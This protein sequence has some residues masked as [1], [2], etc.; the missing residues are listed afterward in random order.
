MSNQRPPGGLDG[1]TH[2]PERERPDGQAGAR[3]PW[4]DPNRTQRYSGRRSIADRL[5]GES[6]E[7]DPPQAHEAEPLPE[8]GAGSTLRIRLDQE[9]SILDHAQLNFYSIV[10]TSN[11]PVIASMIHWDLFQGGGWATLGTPGTIDIDT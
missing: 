5:R 10:V 3:Q 1:P 8:I 7:P 11:T 2:D 9:N 6:R 4:V